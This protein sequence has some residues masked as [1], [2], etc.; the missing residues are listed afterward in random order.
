[1]QISDVDL[2]CSHNAGQHQVLHLTLTVFVTE[3]LTPG[4]EAWLTPR[5][6]LLGVVICRWQGE[7]DAGGSLFGIG[8]G[9]LC[10]CVVFE[11]PL[12]RPRALL[13]S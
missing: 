6:L 3:I 1:M 4:P 13:R 8:T 12:T 10:D 11:E 2:H 9:T 5:V 7:D